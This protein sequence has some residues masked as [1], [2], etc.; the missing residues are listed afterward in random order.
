MGIKQFKQQNGFT[1]VELIAVVA[2]IS[3]IAVYITIEINQSSD[4]AKIGLAIPAAEEG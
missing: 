2:I 3:M 4:D 1:P